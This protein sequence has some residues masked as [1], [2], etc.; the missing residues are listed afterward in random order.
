MQ[1][2]V[3]GAHER[4]VLGDALGLD[5]VADHDLPHDVASWTRGTS[6]AATARRPGSASPGGRAEERQARG[7]EDRRLEAVGERLRRGVAARAGEDGDDD[8]DP[9]HA[10]ELAHHAVGARRLAERAL[11]HRSE[12]RV[13]RGRDGH[14]DADPADDEGREHL[15]VGHAGLGDQRQPGQARGLQAQ[16]G[17]HERPLADLVDERADDRSDGDERR[18][19]RHQP[20]AGAERVVAE[21]GLQQLRVEEHG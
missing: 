11:G 7:D 8:R 13:L 2:L 10:A 17:D 9:E 5:L 19:P 18:G 6:G 14:R 16:P 20:Q 21:P 4:L 1:L 3:D 15:R 12:D